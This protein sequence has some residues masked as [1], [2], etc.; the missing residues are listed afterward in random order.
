MSSAVYGANSDS[1]T[2]TASTASR[3]AGSAPPGPASIALRVALTSSIVARDRDVEA[4][5][6]RSRRRAS[7]TACA[8]ARRSADVATGE[9][10]PGRGW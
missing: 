6:P 9:V 5:A 3:T 1:I 10:D 4:V 2:A 8:V 7:S